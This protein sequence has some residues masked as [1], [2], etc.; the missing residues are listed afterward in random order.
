[1]YKDIFF[2]T[3]SWQKEPNRSFIPLKTPGI[4]PLGLI[5]VIIFQ[6]AVKNMVTMTQKRLTHRSL[7]NAITD[8]LNN[9]SSVPIMSFYR[10]NL[11]APSHIWSI[12]SAHCYRCCR[13]VHDCVIC[14]ANLAFGPIKIFRQIPASCVQTGWLY[15]LITEP[16]KTL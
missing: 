7:M 11:W 4:I 1:M 5:W 9:I 15:V 10:L 16:L 13:R 3:S 6:A 2:L 14:C 8:I 12:I